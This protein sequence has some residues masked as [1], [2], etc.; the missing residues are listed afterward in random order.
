MPSKILTLF[1]AFGLLAFG[2]GV[3][4]A[5]K[6]KAAKVGPAL[7]FKMK[8][9]DG[10]EV[11]LAKYQGKVV[12]MVNVASRCGYTKH[13]KGLQKLYKDH[14]A[15]GLAILGFPCNQF[16]KQE[17]GSDSEIKE[18]CSSKYGV[19]F[20]MFSKIEVN[21]KNAAPLYKYITSIEKPLAA[22][23]QG[24]V[25]WNF[26]KVLVDKSGKVIKRYRSSVTPAKIEA[27]ILKALA[28]K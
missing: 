28:K 6:K 9:I 5:A 12:L 23:N 17:K 10:K 4:D 11:D 15:S 2:T 3:A 24:K 8:N 27:D 1:V 21:G 22:K 14:K 19:T 16:G 25:R 18:F 26:E 20:D 13:Y 7:K